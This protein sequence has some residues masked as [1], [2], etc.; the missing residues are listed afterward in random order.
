[1]FLSRLQIDGPAVR[2]PYEIHRLLWKCFPSM[3]AAARPFLFR[4]QWPRGNSP[5]EVLMQSHVEPSDPDEKYCRFLSIPGQ[6]N[7]KS[8]KLENLPEQWYRFVLCANPVKRLPMPER[9]RIGPRVPL[10]KTEQQLD[11]LTNRFSEVAEIGEAQTIDSR[12][13][14][15]RKGG[16]AGKISTVIFTGLLKV[17]N[18]QAMAERIT[19]GIGPAKSFGCGLLS[20]ARI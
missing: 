7:P 1:M 16:R 17:V 2:N 10:I 20:L 14:H 13:L 12:I 11:W 4:V 15:F 8:F 18:G 5:A 19:A 3:A 6:P 9:D